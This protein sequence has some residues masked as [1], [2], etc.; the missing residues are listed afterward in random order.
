MRIVRAMSLQKKQYR[1]A[2]NRSRGGVK[3]K[4]LDTSALSNGKT[5][6]DYGR[7]VRSFHGSKTDEVQESLSKQIVRKKKYG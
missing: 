4:A 1:S 5:P 3:G 7:N 6:K 2:A